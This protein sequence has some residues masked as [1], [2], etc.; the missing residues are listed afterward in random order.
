MDSKGT[1]SYIYMYSFPQKR[2]S[3]VALVAKNP[4]A[5]AETRKMQVPSLGQEDPLEEGMA[6]HSHGKKCLVGYSPWDHK[7][8]DTT[9]AA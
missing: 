7:E 2:A 1:Q 6:P 3:Q 4:T 9:E 5:D 8:L